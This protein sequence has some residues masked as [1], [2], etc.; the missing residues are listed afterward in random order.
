MNP[1][2]LLAIERAIALNPDQSAG[3]LAQTTQRAA[4]AKAGCKLPRRPGH[5]R[6][7]GYANTNG[8]ASYPPRGG[9]HCARW[10]LPQPPAA[11]PITYQG[12]NKSPLVN[13]SGY[14]AFPRV[15]PP[16]SATA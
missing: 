11:K 3:D 7:A 12:M 15:P 4:V 1:V 9:G 14:N 8:A 5:A 13:V 16:A 2:P 10:M 6:R